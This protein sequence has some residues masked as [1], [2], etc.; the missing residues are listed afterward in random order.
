MSRARSVLVVLAL[1]G[2][3][4]A[5]GCVRGRTVLEVAIDPSALA[6]PV[7]THDFT[8]HEAAVRG[9][10]AIM[11]QEMQLPVPDEVTVYVYGTRELFEEGL[12]RD[13]SVSRR[14]AKE[15][16]H[17]ASGIGK[18]RQLLI[19]DAAVEA[20]GREWLQLLAHELTHVVQIELARGEGRYEQ[21]LSEGMA[22]WVAIAVLE[23]LGI[24]T[25][26]DRRAMARVAMRGH[27]PVAGHRLDLASLGTPRGFI[28][29]HQAE[30]LHA[31]YQLAFL[32]SDYLIE[33][34][35]LRTFVTYFRLCGAGLSRDE[36]FRLAF[37]VTVKE[38]EAEVLDYLAPAGR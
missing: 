23:R 33:Q 19:N 22:E 24:D 30:G 38:F 36:S 31:T 29:R 9:I 1:A 7:N 26:I 8:T 32:M 5:S 12:M 20:R 17:F 3:V 37:G 27:P 4:L 13:G 11:T 15:L 35:G 10:A 14:R 18:R 28:E 2:A 21:W 6:R 16:S 25:L 34:H